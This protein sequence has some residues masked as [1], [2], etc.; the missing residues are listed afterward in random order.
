MTKLKPS[1]I[2]VSFIP[3][4][5]RRPS[6]SGDYIC[7]M[8]GY[9]TTLSYSKKWDKFNMLD[10]FAEKDLR[11]ALEPIAWAFLNPLHSTLVERYKEV[12]HE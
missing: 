1:C 7:V 12:D 6:E 5:L 10:K 4:K 2:P 9:I 3:C 11:M 8:D